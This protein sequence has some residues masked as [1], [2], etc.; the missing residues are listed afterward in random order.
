M[1]KMVPSGTVIFV[2]PDDRELIDGRFYAM[3]RPGGETTFKQLRTAPM[4]LEPC[5]NNPSYKPILVG[6][7]GL[8]TLG[9]VLGAHLDF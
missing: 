3:F 6:D 7:E 5:S 4:R 8:I 9:R 2:D 1:D